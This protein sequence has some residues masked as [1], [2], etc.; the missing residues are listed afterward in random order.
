[1]QFSKRYMATRNA[2]KNEENFQ[3]KVFSRQN[4]DKDLNGFSKIDFIITDDFEKRKSLKLLPTFIRINDLLPG[5]PEFMKLRKP[6]VVRLH[7][8]SREKN[9]HEF[10]FSELQ[11]YRPFTNEN[12]LCPDSIDKCKALYDEISDHNGQRKVTNIKQILME[13]LE[14]VEDG[15]EKANDFLQSNAGALMDPEAE[16]DVLLAVRGQ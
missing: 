10:Y 15:T 13:H 7:K 4:G 9:P 8:I 3:P 14:S 11:L 5:E 16:Q 2:P 6:Y 1:M 12:T